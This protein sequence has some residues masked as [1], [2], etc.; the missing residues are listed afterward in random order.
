MEV[1]HGGKPSES[2]E[3]KVS[4]SIARARYSTVGIISLLR[5]VACHHLMIIL[6]FD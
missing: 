4:V 1:Q 3:Q 2:G 6:K 5:V